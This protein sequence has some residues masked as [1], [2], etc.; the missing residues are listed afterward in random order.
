MVD[1]MAALDQKE[2]E[3]EK[4]VDP[5]QGTYVWNVNKA[6]TVSRTKSGEWDIIEFPMAAVS[7]E[8]D[9]DA[10][11]LDGYGAV[12]SIFS[13]ISFLSPTAED[14]DNDRKK[15]LDRIWKFL[16]RTLRVDGLDDMSLKQ[17][18]DASVAH[19]CLGQLVWEPRKDSPDE[20][21]VNL[22]NYAPLD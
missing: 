13:R 6:P 7:A 14:K 5:P 22:K 18:L 4:P 8:D 21:N 15:T 3:N 19:R 16:E 17:A 1:F 10:D 11:D 2:E 9:V 12:S 20:I